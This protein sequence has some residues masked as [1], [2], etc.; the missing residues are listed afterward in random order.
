MDWGQ[1]ENGK[2][3]AFRSNAMYLSQLSDVAP[4]FGKFAS[5]AQALRAVHPSAA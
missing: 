4:E 1:R 5:V 2:E 3:L